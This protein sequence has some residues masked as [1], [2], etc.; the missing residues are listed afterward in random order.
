MSCQVRLGPSPKAEEDL[1]TDTQKQG[2]LTTE[3]EAAVMLPQA[4]RHQNGHL[5][6]EVGKDSEGPLQE[7]SDGAQP[8]S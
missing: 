1:G 3:A 5:S 4:Q 6:S 8:W 7:P 2:H